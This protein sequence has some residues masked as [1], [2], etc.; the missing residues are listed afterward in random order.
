MFRTLRRITVASLR[1]AEA[2][3]LSVGLRP[4]KTERFNRLMQADVL[5]AVQ[6][7]DSAR[8]VVG[9]PF[10]KETANIAALVG[11]TKRDLE[12]LSQDAA[13]V[14]VGERKT[15]PALLEAALPMSSDRVKIV[16]LFKPLG[17]GQRPGL[18]RRS[19]S[20]W[21]ILQVANR[22]EA[23]VVFIDA[24]VRNS[25]GWIHQYLE[26][27]Q[28]RGADLAVANYV[29][30]FDQ[31]DAIVHIW[32]RL[33]F[34]AVFHRW[35]AFRHG[36][37]YAISHRLLPGILADASIMRERAYTMD[38]AV[39]AHVVRR[40]GRIESIWLAAK[41][42]EP[43][44]RAN[45]FSRLQTLVHSVFDDVDAHLPAVLRW[46]RKTESLQP[47][48]NPATSS[49]MRDLI[50]P[51]FRQE[52]HADMATRFRAAAHDIRKTLGAAGF[53]RFAALAHQRTAEQVL[54]SPRH[55][56]KATMRI[57]GRYVGAR[58]SEQKSRLAR[59]CVPILE[60]G[61]L[62]FL[63]ASYNLVYADAFR[64][65]DTEYLPAFQLRWDWLSRR[66]SAYRFTFWR[67]APAAVQTWTSSRRLLSLAGELRRLSRMLPRHVRHH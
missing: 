15:R 30:R 50:G 65:L 18:A 2:A 23:D 32:D 21:A 10:Y 36:G 20:H 3:A 38:S 11:K 27:I 12:S 62:G 51:E 67:L 41:V 7:I 19:W 29:R 16:A 45:L 52:L 55:W 61:I 34:G 4:W 17:F 22:L 40:G 63:N 6:T 46:P 64:L 56:A 14:I 53:E 5:S 24:D 59:A 13:I 26:A 66:L 8:V 43:I 39:M 49:R 33:I 37:D 60:A 42:H 57:L 35:I 58:D 31:D 1:A 47:P 9:I 48:A 44:T 54:L 28:E 25:E